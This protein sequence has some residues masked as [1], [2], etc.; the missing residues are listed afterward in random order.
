MKIAYLLP[1]LHITGG[2][3]AVVELGGKMVNRGHEFNILIPSGRRKLKVENG[4]N[5][6]ECGLG[7]GSPLLAVPFG[8]ISM[9][10]RIPQVDIVIGSMPTHA[11]TALLI[12]NRRGIPAVNYILGNDVHFF[13][14]KSHLKSSPLVY[15][16]R[17]VARIAIKANF[18]LANSHQTA[19]WCVSEKGRRPRAIVNSGFNPDYFYPPSDN[20]Q[21]DQI[22]SLITIGRKQPSKGLAD[23]IRAL[24]KLNL[25]ENQFKLSV[26]SQENPDMTSAEFEFEIVRPQSDVEL[27]NIYRSGDIYINSSW[28]EGFGLPSLEA[29]A[30]GLAVISTNCGGVREF[31]VDG[32]NSMI[33]PPREPLSLCNAIKRLMRDD[34]LRKRLIG[35]GLKSCQ[36]FTWEAV[37]K[38]FEVAL[39]DIISDFAN[40]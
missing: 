17:K 14:D 35:T 12:G 29:Q 13:D 22:R 1:N 6:I 5:V 37:S 10:R 3:R 30:C 7:V 15:I 11:L 21:D 23:L 16:Y 40:E 28:S 36:K 19:V 38:K 2:A 4:I 26:I 25:E 31:L 39:D 9:L 8:I 34:P 33:V 32:E 27:A 20:A 18:I 24:N